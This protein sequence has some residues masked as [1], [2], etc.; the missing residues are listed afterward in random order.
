MFVLHV[1][2]QLLYIPR[3]PNYWMWYAR[4]TE[5]CPSCTGNGGA[6]CSPNSTRNQTGC[7]CAAGNNVTVCID[8]VTSCSDMTCFNGGSCQTGL[9]PPICQCKWNGGFQGKQ[10]VS[11]ENEC[12]KEACGHGRCQDGVR[13]Y[14]CTCAVGYCGFL[15]EDNSS[16]SKVTPK[17]MFIV[18]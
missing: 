9:G 6:T 12:L 18:M 7:A 4:L 11:D 10:C 3:W 14:T 16:C 8:E 5:V 1:G 13:D 2:I 17:G 15:C